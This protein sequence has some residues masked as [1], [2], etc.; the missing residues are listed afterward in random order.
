MSF[1]YLIYIF[2][3]FV[4][5]LSSFYKTML[6]FRIIISFIIFLCI[7]FDYEEDKNIKTTKQKNRFNHYID[8]ADDELLH[9][10]DYDKSIINLNKINTTDHLINL[11]DDFFSLLKWNDPPTKIIK[12]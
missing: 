5:F 11:M 1:I 8:E 12:I 9:E 7:L 4:S 10:V 2:C 6:I 3:V